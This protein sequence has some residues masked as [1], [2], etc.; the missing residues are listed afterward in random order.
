M[1][2]ARR[3]W[4][5]SVCEAE[6]AAIPSPKGAFF[7]SWRIEPTAM[8]AICRRRA[9]SHYNET[10][11]LRTLEAIHRWSVCGHLDDRMN[12][13]EQPVVENEPLDC[14]AVLEITTSKDC[15]AIVFH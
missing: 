4:S 8:S 11:R 15:I 6:V 3:F 10:P 14:A 7:I 1:D 2:A 13:F 5:T 9:S 12:M